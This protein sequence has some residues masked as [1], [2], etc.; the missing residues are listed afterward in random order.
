MAVT[1]D[2]E[3]IPEG[4]APDIDQLYDVAVEGARHAASTVG[5]TLDEFEFSAM[6]YRA[7]A[8]IKADALLSAANEM[9]SGQSSST[10]YWDGEQVK[11][12]GYEISPN[13]RHP[14]DWLR[15]RALATVDKKSRLVH[16]GG[17]TDPD[18]P[19]EIVIEGSPE[20]KMVSR[21]RSLHYQGSLHPMDQGQIC[22][23]CGGAWPCRT[24]IIVE[25]IRI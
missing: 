24:M 3:P 23:G 21:L 4:F 17:K 12:D 6:F 7:I 10:E 11:Y 20:S 18:E 16:L 15:A 14:R 2:G 25:D 9:P 1:M 5:Q 19:Y 8:E 22:I 13:S